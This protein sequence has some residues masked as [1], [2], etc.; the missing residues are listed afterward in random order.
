VEEVTMLKNVGNFQGTELCGVSA[1][2]FKTGTI[3]KCV[4]AK[5]L[6]SVQNQGLVDAVAVWQAEAVKTI[7]ALEATGQPQNIRSANIIKARLRRLAD[8]S[9]QGP[10]HI[11][12]AFNNEGKLIDMAADEDCAPACPEHSGCIRWWWVVALGMGAAYLGSRYK[13]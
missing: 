13:K 8:E 5:C 4:P 3:F 10:S 2:K 11:S 9:P 12:L 1:Q 6:R 7:G